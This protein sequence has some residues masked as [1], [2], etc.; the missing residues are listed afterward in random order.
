MGWFLVAQVTQECE[1]FKTNK[2]KPKKW[3]M[4]T[5]AMKSLQETVFSCSCLEKAL[6]A[7]SSDSSFMVLVVSSVSAFVSFAA[8]SACSTVLAQQSVLCS[9]CPEWLHEEY[10]VVWVV[11]KVWLA[12]VFSWQR[13]MNVL[14]WTMVGVSSTVRTHWAVTNAPVSLA[15]SWQL[16][17]RAVK[18]SNLQVK[19]SDC[20]IG[21]TAK[22]G[23]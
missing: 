10:Q 14:C 12:L 8:V 3:H 16:I 20:R 13:W 15:M 19:P 17:K 21:T 1:E 6:L 9:F 4:R 23:I 5:K 22:N 18:V 11:R 7:G 2:T